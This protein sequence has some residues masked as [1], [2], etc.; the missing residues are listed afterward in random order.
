MNKTCRIFYAP[1]EDAP[2][3]A[4]GAA[5]VLA[6]IPAEET[7]TETSETIVPEKK[8]TVV[9]EKREPDDDIPEHLPNEGRSDKW[10]QFRGQYQTTKK[11]RDELKT[12][13]DTELADF[14]GTKKERDELK[15]RITALETERA[16][17]TEIDSV[18]KLENSPTFR[19]EYIHPRQKAV[20]SLKEL[21]GYADIDPNTLTGALNKTGKA[22]YEALEEALATAPASLRGRIERTIDQID[23]LDARAN[24]ERA[25]AETALRDRETKAQQISRERRE[26]FQK[27]ATETFERTA[28][29]LKKELGIEDGV[30]E[31]ARQFY[32]KNDDLSAAAKMIIRAHAADKSDTEKAEMKKT[33]DEMA[34]ELARYKK[35]SPGLG[36]GTHER[37]GALDSKTT[38]I[39]GAL[40]ALRGEL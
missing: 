26:Q 30:I 22:R 33:I 16:K 2:S 18:V 5:A 36:G 14:E 7:K 40:K 1:D 39:G 23:E 4:A 3:F 38:F 15:G 13:L 37:S 27:Q 12:R 28:A 21:S 24:E 10:K 29:E 32:T 6:G 25:N 9:T 31:A 20:D 35:A 17:W 19:A 34:A 11:E 8:E